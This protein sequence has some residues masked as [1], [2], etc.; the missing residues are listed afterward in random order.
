MNSLPERHDQLLIA[1]HQLI[2]TFPL[3]QVAGR[4]VATTREQIR[5]ILQ[6]KDNRLLVI[7]GPCSIHDTQAALEYAG[8]L[9]AAADRFVDDLCIVMRV[10]F[11]K[12]R[13]TV[14]WRGLITDPYMDG[15]YAMNHGLHMA[16][17][18]LVELNELGVPAATEFLDTLIPV[19]L[20]DLISWSAIGART[21]ESQI[22]REMAS[23]LSMPVGFKNNTDGNIKV[24][25]DAVNVARHPHVFLGM[26]ES[27]VPAM[28]RT[29]GNKWGH[30]ILRGSHLASNYAAHIIEET[31]E[32]LMH[33]QLPS[34]IMIDCSHGNSMKDYKLQHQVIAE[35]IK[36]LTAGSALIHGVMLESNLIAGKQPLVQGNSLVYGQSITDGCLGWQD[37]LSLLEDLAMS[38]RL[39]SA[40]LS[41]AKTEAT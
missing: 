11:E 38:H 41:M 27:G 33:A 13:T 16:R 24:A 26:T 3:S 37:T 7:V 25:I 21:V 39:T 17:K 4:T 22:H 19:Y 6:A 35:I 14:G 20:G 28:I 8:L 9:K 2:K 40:R 36:Q 31:A 32:L 23:G 30:I 5:H 12:P 34:R 18:L 10:Y 15:S 29:E 1:P